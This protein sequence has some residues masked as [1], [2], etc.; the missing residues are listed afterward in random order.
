MLKVKLFLGKIINKKAMKLFNEIIG[1]DDETIYKV[2]GKLYRL[3]TFTDIF[4]LDKT[5]IDTYIMMAVEYT[6]LNKNH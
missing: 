3:R 4:K 1:S 5:V 6:E 2:V